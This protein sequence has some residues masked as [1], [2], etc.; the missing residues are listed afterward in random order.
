MDANMEKTQEKHYLSQKKYDELVAELNELKT[1]RR[2]E[3]ADRLEF[4]KSLGDLSEN[5][6]YHAAREEQADVEDRIAQIEGIL[7]TCEIVTEYH[8][9]MVGVGSRVVVKKVGEKTESE[10]LIVGPEEVDPA[11]GKIS[12]L[13][14]LGSKLMGSKSGVKLVVTTPKGAVNYEIVKIK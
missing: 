6:E 8:G 4:A 9:G 1:S 2:K 11:Q 14:P 13:S 5:A 7:K 3:I 12:Y 10:I